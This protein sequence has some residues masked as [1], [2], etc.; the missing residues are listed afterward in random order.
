M[1]RVETA[2][3]ETS[4][5]AGGAS[6][7][8]L[9]ELA[10][11]IERVAALLAADALSAPDG[12]AALERIADIA[13]VLHERDIEASLYDGLAAAVHEL[14]KAEQLKQANA[15]R[16]QQALASLRE[17][18]RRVNDM[19]APTHAEQRNEPPAAIDDATP[20][21]S[22]PA[23]AV[24]DD[25]TA[26]DAM[27]SGGLFAMEVREDAASSAVPAGAPV[28]ESFA[29]IF[30]GDPALPPPSEIKAGSGEDV[31][32]DEK[33]GSDNVG[34]PFEAEPSRTPPELQALLDPDEDPGDLFEPLAG[35][36]PANEKA[37]A[38]FGEAVA[39]AADS[40]GDFGLEDL[41][42]AFPPQSP[43]AP[44]PPA[45]AA[46]PQAAALPV[47]NDPLAP[48]RALSEEELIALF[49]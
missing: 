29:A 35:D 10:A 6:P 22:A 9:S 48:M 26:H 8:D 32:G 47:A 12:S 4:A 20:S 13:F 39:A 2:S 31:S 34:P 14:A 40:V 24:A 30:L 23:G 38:V 27:K 43:P 18:A 1:G 33:P 41:C 42:D 25:G 44:P 11:A 7:R 17:L 45:V 21:E 16:A 19:I 36:V 5:Q 3:D 37:G 49:S 46:A 28:I 15:A